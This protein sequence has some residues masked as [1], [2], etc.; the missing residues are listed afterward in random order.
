LAGIAPEVTFWPES[1]FFG[2]FWPD[3]TFRG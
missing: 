2:H 1:D 3:L